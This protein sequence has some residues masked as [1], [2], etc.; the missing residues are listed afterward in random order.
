MSKFEPKKTGNLC[1]ECKWADTTIVYAS[2]PPMYFCKKFETYVYC[3]QSVCE[4]DKPKPVFQSYDGKT[5]NV[6]EDLS[7]AVLKAEFEA[8]TK[9]MPERISNTF[10]GLRNSVWFYGKPQ[11]C[12]FEP[13]TAPDGH[14][15]HWERKSG[16]GWSCYTLVDDTVAEL[17]ERREKSEKKEEEPKAEDPKAKDPWLTEEEKQHL[18]E[19][20][21]A[22]L[23]TKEG[24]EWGAMMRECFGIGRKKGEPEKESQKEEPEQCPNDSTNGKPNLFLCDK[25][26][27]EF[28]VVSAKVGRVQHCP[29]CGEEPRRVKE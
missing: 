28:R 14:K 8:R 23:R 25:C 27:F 20:T 3:D 19:D 16:N 21:R 11:V 18:I 4:E 13:F 29:L 10:R 26:D 22:F 7:A 1:R 15:C 17:E 6:A 2:Y 5:P 24:A 12:K 9:D